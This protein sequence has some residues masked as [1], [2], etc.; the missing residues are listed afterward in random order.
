MSL[1][2]VGVNSLLAVNEW[3]G[4]INSNL[5]AS[6]RTAYKTSRVSFTD[7]LGS[8]TVS[9]DRLLPPSTLTVE[10]TT[11][12]WGQGPIINDGEQA[13]FAIQGEG[14]FVL[15]DPHTGKYF[16]SRD[17]EFHWGD[18]GYLVNSAGLRVVSSGQDFIQRGISDQSDIFSPDGYSRDLI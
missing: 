12:E 14:F 5:Q 7:G 15:C 9:I 2:Q 17:G 1:S 3:I 4:L 16:L 10:A 13:H 18:S 8:N 11:I 6:S